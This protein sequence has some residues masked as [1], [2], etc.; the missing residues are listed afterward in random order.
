M[1]ADLLLRLIALKR[2]GDIEVERVE[3]ND[4]V[5]KERLV[6]SSNLERAPRF[7]RR[8]ESSRI[9]DF[10]FVWSALV[11]GNYQTDSYELDTRLEALMV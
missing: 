2:K 10:T 7:W 5:G 9:N 3:L 6:E 8:L 11:D 1:R 4:C